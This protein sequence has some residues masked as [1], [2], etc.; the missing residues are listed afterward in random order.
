MNYIS[1]SPTSGTIGWDNVKIDSDSKIAIFDGSSK[2]EDVV[3][4][5]N[6]TDLVINNIG[7]VVLGPSRVVYFQLNLHLRKP[8]FCLFSVGRDAGLGAIRRLIAKHNNGLQGT[9]R[10]ATR[11]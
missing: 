10:F 5:G 11:P 1:E 2:L 6:T 7:M 9:L 8:N 3:V 4:D